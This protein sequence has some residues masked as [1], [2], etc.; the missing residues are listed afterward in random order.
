MKIDLNRITFKSGISIQNQAALIP[1][2]QAWE[3]GATLKQLCETFKRPLFSI[4]AILLKEYLAE[5]IHAKMPPE[6]DP[7]YL[8]F[9]KVV[10][11]KKSLV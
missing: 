3:Q 9:L 10:N 4:V 8:E 1:I 7:L 5:D 11:N 6:D 2:Y